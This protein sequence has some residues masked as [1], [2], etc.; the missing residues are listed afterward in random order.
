MKKLLLKFKETV[1]SVLPITLIVLILGLT[2]APLESEMIW[3]FIVG[4]VFV[5]IG[6][7]LF[8]LGAEISMIQM[9]EK[10]GAS[11][12]KQRNI[13]LIV[14]VSF[15]LGII[16]TIAEPDLL[17]LAEQ[18]SDAINEYV[19]IVA[20]GVGVGI[21]LVIALLRIV[22]QIKLR[23]LLLIFYPIVF[24]I[25]IF[26]PENFLSVAFDSGGV[27]TGPITVPF[28]MALGIGVASLSNKNN[29]EDSFGLV[30]LC[31]IGPIISVF[32]LGMFNDTSEL[33]YDSVLYSPTGENI[34]LTFIKEIPYYMSE[35]AI[36][37]APVFVFFLI[38]QFAKLPIKQLIK[39]IIGL[40]YDYIGLVIFLTGV[41]V[42]FLPAG[43]MIGSLIGISKYSWVLIPIGILV[44]FFIVAAE[45]AVHVLN[46]QVEEISG[47]TIKKRNM[48]IALM[49]GTGL[50]LA[51]SM[52][53]VLTGISIWWFIVP[54]Y[55]IALILTFFV[56]KVFTSVAFDSG[57]VASGPMTATF[58]LPFAIGASNSLGGNI[59]SDAF[60]VVAMVA[61]TPLVTIQL[62]GLFYAI[63]LKKSKPTPYALPMPEKI[64]EEEL[65]LNTEDAVIENGIIDF[66]ALNNVE[67]EI[68][69]T[70]PLQEN[71]NKSQDENVVII[72]GEKTSGDKD[73]ELTD[74]TNKNTELKKD[75]D[76]T[77]NSNNEN[78][79]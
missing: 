51:F 47:G 54:V 36:A 62:M 4:A 69:D 79:K 68:I 61:M 74:K 42:G 16:V 22:F 9:G 64:L 26:V 72:L 41:N 7:S 34:L 21:F 76:S 19:L 20:V 29:A 48:L 35:V 27:T 45:P 56:P 1:F 6:M 17:V 12:T 55:A 38:Y 78:E 3:S 25:G 33:A 49:C 15:I 44:G 50:S 52:I 67:T 10:I 65:V 73:N 37:L 28:I 58:L 2:I 11:I 5:I 77:D 66:S 18:L 32:I 70:V 63:K 59:M 23:T 39:I 40:V 13:Y 53:R 57:G 75:S 71:S 30:A 43:N 14:I 46:S 8:S 24:L 31:S 60:G